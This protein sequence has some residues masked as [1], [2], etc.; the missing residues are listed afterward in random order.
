MEAPNRFIREYEQKLNTDRVLRQSLNPDMVRLEGLELAD[1]PEAGWKISQ[2]DGVP[3]PEE[4]RRANFGSIER[5]RE[6]RP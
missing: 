1:P 2:T 4:P 6:D 3:I 5:F